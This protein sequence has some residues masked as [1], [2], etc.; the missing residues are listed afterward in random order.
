LSKILYGH[1]T[2]PN[3]PREAVNESIY[4]KKRNPKKISW[5]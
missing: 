2:K 3:Y 1:T 4:R 5:K